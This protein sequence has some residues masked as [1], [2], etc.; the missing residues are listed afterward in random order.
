MAWPRHSSAGCRLAVMT[1][2]R[3]GSG[4]RE[5]ERRA[6]AAR[7]GSP[8]ASASAFGD[9]P[10]GVL[11]ACAIEQRDHAAA[12]DGC[13]D[14]EDGH[15]AAGQECGREKLRHGA[16]AE[17]RSLKDERVPA[18]RRRGG[19]SVCGFSRMVCSSVLRRRNLPW[20]MGVVAEGETKDDQDAEDPAKRATLFV[21]PARAAQTEGCQTSGRSPERT[22]CADQDRP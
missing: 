20:M 2:D 7:G 1:G 4:P 19:R 22:C 16:V 3:H 5:L 10:G 6:D 11:N 18:R 21:Q 17:R 9:E 14:L 15:A 8:R 12:G 13:G